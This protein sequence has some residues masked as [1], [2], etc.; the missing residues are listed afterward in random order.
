MT[1]TWF[2]TGT[3]S[4]FGRIMT[5]TLLARGD[6]VAAT[7]RRP[8]RLA[9]LAD[10]YGDRLWLADLDVTDTARLRAVADAAFAH[11]GRID[12]VVSNAGYGLLGAAEE[13][14]DAAI[15]RQ[16]DTNVLG[17]MQ[18]FRAV[19]P[20]LRRQGGG[21]FLQLSSMGG[22][23]AFPGL[24]L[25]HAS[26]W[27]MEGFFEAAAPEVAAFGIGVTLIE[28]GAAST[29]FGSTGADLAAPLAVYA[30][31][32]AGAI[33]RAFTE[34]G[35]PVPGDPERMVARMVEVAEAAEAPL[36]LALGS[37]A[38]E[39]IRA[40]LLGRLAALDAQEAVARSTDLGAG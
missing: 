40:A 10:N 33:R 23:M 21:R 16:I 34:G 5:E 14:D 8:E 6:R 7:L 32:P 24:S 1:K 27:A 28:P 39:Q 37:D 38:Y 19:V 30:D 3:S 36:R 15:R 2:I 26:K 17:S 12:V 25:Y 22:Q 20:H 18:L 31:T 35:F 11:F 29:G 9:G 13:L 4:G